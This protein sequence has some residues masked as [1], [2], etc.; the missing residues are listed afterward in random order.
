MSGLRLCVEVLELCMRVLGPDVRFT[1]DLS[2]R[3]WDLRASFGMCA[4]MYSSY[5]VLL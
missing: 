1:W 2:D 4:Y 3:T 5:S